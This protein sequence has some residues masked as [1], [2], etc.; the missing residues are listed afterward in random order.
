MSKFM[1]R[2]LR[3]LRLLMATAMVSSLAVTAPATAFAESDDT[4]PGIAAPASPFEG[5]VEA[6]GDV[7]DI[8]RFNLTEGQFIS[9]GVTQ[10]TEATASVGFF[11]PDATEPL[12]PASAISSAT[13]DSVSTGFASDFTARSGQA[14][15]YYLG[16]AAIS[17]DSTYTVSW[18][19]SDPS[20][21]LDST[22]TAVTVVQGESAA[23]RFFN[24]NWGEL[25]SVPVTFTAESDQAWLTATPGSGEA[26]SNGSQKLTL[27]TDTSGLAIGSHEATVTVRILG[28]AP[29]TH[30]VSVNVLDPDTSEPDDTLPGIS[31]P[32]S[33]FQ[34]AVDPVTDKRDV[35][36]FDLTE[37]QFLHVDVAQTTEATASVGL[38]GPDA[39][40]PLDPASAISSATVTQGSDY[41]GDFT[42]RTGQA[43]AY[44]LNVAAISGTSTYTVDWSI[45]DPS[46]SLDSTSTAVTVVQGES[47]ADRFFNANWGELGSVPVTFTAES[48]Q[49]WLTATPGS[50]EASSNGSQKLTLKTDTSGLA[51]GSHEATVTVRILGAAPQTHRVSVNVLEPTVARIARSAPKARVTRSGSLIVRYGTLVTLR[52][53]LR[54]PAGVL[55]P[56][57]QMTL[58]R[59]YDRKNWTGVTSP[60]SATGFYAAST[61]VYR[62]TYFRWIYSGDDATAAS[63][64]PTALVYSYAY[65]TPPKNIPS[66]V[67][68][69][70]TYYFYGYLKPK[71]THGANAIRLQFQYYYRGRWRTDTSLAVK[72]ADYGSYYSRYRYADR[73]VRGVP[74][75]WRVRAVHGDSSHLTTYSSW[76]YYKVY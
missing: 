4:L 46:F 41:V 1:R 64:T 11:G 58:Q 30:H 60:I 76:R 23:D 31:A 19:I 44:Y 25:G 74:R 75:S 16:V 15:D 26:S 32:P 27:K 49:A 3:G 37:G 17:G 67:R 36:S 13:I 69:N 53:S 57:K 68:P 73:Y 63:V 14:G 70:R 7:V 51:I 5:S 21:S 28:A 24:A 55:V 42:A 43:G 20:F 61:K 18:S 66:R 35:Y 59:S 50:G 72:I 38:F 39:T 22:S 52:A 6:T 12:D 34:G 29:Q 56:S 47:A 9:L 54:N 10:T 2:P 40:E 71:H 8:Y 33:P 45:S 48:D 65:V 62:K